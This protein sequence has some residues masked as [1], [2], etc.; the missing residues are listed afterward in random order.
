MGRYS[1][2]SLSEYRKYLESRGLKKIRSK[3][4]HEV[5]SR[6]DLL[7]PVIIQS[8]I[9]PI[10]ELILRSNARTMGVDI[11]DLLDFLKSRS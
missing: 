10:P 1:N 2:I 11:S 3:G 7:R 4:G 8:H 9:S 5:W 6:S